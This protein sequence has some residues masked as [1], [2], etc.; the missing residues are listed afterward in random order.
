MRAFLS[1]FGG[2]ITFLTL[3]PT[4]DRRHC[5]FF[6]TCAKSG[7]QH[8]NFSWQSFVTAFRQVFQMQDGISAIRI[9]AEVGH[10][11]SI[12][13]THGQTARWPHGKQVNVYCLPLMV[14][15]LC[16]WEQRS[17]NE[18]RTQNQMLVLKL[19]TAGNECCFYESEQ[20][21][22]HMTSYVLTFF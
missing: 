19:E 9:S 21:K 18:N 13:R 12:H 6:N 2:G 15:T 7:K 8:C 1:V 4:G 17:Q 20:Y 10:M 3:I 11:N 5:P 16:L 14:K 22:T